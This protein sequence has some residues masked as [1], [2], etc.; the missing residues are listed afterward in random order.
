MTGQVLEV[1]LAKPQ[2]D[3]KPDGLYPYT[4][5]IH[6]NQVTHSSYGG[7]AGSPYGSLSAS[8][9]SGFGV[10]ASFQQVFYIN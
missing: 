3:K 9:G 7:F 4:A 8:A 10:T 2:A 5:G 6:P 1:V